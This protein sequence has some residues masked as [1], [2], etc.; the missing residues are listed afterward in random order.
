MLLAGP[1][2]KKPKTLI[3]AEAAAVA[4]IGGNVIIQFQ[5]ATGDDTG[6]AGVA[7]GLPV[8]ACLEL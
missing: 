5:S 6:V 2:S 1:P 4:A 8:P 3:A 7:N